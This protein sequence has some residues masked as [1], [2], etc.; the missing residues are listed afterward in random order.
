MTALENESIQLSDGRTLSY[1]V[2]GSPV[3]RTTIIYMHGFPSS[4]LEGKL[5]HSKCATRGIRLISPDRPGSGLS[6][7]QPN[8]SII[9]WPADI[10]FLTEHLKIDQFY[11]LG[12]S[13]GAPYTLACI[14]R[15]TKERILGATLASAIYPTKL[16]TEG[17]MLQ[18][19]LLF[20]IAPWMTGLTS[21]LFDSLVGNAAR[22]KNPSI[23]EDLVAKDIQS[24]HI[25]DQKAIKD[26]INWPICVAMGR[27]AF[28][29]GSRG[30]SWEARLYGSDWGFDLGDLNVDYEGVRL[31]I[32]HG[33]E[34]VN[35][36]VSMAQRASYMMP[37]SELHIKH[38]DG[39]VNYLFRD[40]DE[41]LDTMMQ[42]TEVEEFVKVSVCVS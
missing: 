13:G 36:P 28:R 23:F 31:T 11:L 2:Y 22:H 19:R 37:G 26:P 38:G 10:L 7:F 41:I 24:R 40:A 15:I 27:E 35:V 32:W 34:D 14:H 42:K 33:D 5:W 9:D 3:P 4:R 21:L 8:R 1:A 30:A 6:S 39:H 20:W 16:G 12:V 29:E 17:M 25:E 18:S